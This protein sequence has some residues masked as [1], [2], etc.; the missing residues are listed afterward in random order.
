MGMDGYFPVPELLLTFDSSDLTGANIMMDARPLY[1]QGWHFA[2]GTYAPNGIDRVTPL[3]RI[4]YPVR[5]IIIDYEHSIRF[6][7]GQTHLVNSPGGRDGSAPEIQSYKERSY[8][9]FKLDV[10]TVGNLLK[11][12]FWKACCDN[13]SRMKDQLLNAVIC[14]QQYQ[15]LDFLM[16]L[17]N[18]MMVP[19]FHQRCAAQSALQLW[20]GVVSSLGRGFGRRRLRKR[21]ESVG[22]RVF[23]AINYFFAIGV[24]SLRQM[25]LRELT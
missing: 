12:E 1:P 11:E 21:D 2:K 7:P 13:C 14:I 15:G 3:A 9:A 5:Y 10:F 16:S 22:D 24:Y 6:L 19:D 23:N 17:T 18:E 20:L 8:D 25:L 4:D